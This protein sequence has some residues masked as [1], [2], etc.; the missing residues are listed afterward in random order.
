MA[1]EEAARA[2]R[3]Q[4]ARDR[5][6]RERRSTAARSLWARSLLKASLSAAAILAAIYGLR[7][8][9]D[10]LRTSSALAIEEIVF[11]GASRAHREELLALS[12]LA[13]G[14]NML[15][16][17]REEV[18]EAIRMHPWVREAEVHRVGLN[19]VRV[20][21]EELQPVLLV[22]LDHLYYANAQGRIV[23]RYAPGESVAFPVLT[24]L[25]RRDLMD[26]P[27]EV[28]TR[29]REA[30]AL[31][32]AWEAQLAPAAP[33]LSEIHLD[34]AGELGVVLKDEPLTVALGRPP[35]AAAIRRFTEVRAALAK[36]GVRARRISLSGARRGAVAELVAS[37]ED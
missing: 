7:W 15:D 4:R 23:K 16:F 6:L 20:T 14:A 13:V 32:Q 12:G 36:D 28:R 24:G 21:V 34:Q 29:L 3:D 31:A 10:G 18:A 19:A 1:A 37:A 2:R 33:A 30:L 25:S 26:R 27:E 35:F 9:E 5:A 17:D 8:A 11:E 22:A